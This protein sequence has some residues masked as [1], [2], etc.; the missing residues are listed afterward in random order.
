VGGTAYY[1]GAY[2]TQVYLD[3]APFA[4]AGIALRL[5]RWRAPEYPQLHG[6][7]VPDLSIVDLMAHCGAASRAMLLAA[8]DD[9]A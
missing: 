5:Q 1:T 4:A 9:S 7:F 8:G 6:P 2:A 3:P